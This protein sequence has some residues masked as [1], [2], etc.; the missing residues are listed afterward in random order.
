MV[1]RPY[2]SRIEFWSGVAVTIY[3]TL[4][5]LIE[6]L[7]EKLKS[8]GIELSEDNLFKYDYEGYE[9]ESEEWTDDDDEEDESSDREMLSPSSRK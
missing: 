9:S 2:S 5:A 7:E 1:V 6:K 3:G 8:Q 4:C